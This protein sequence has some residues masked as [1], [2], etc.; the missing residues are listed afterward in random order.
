MGN[1]LLIGCSGN[2]GTLVFKELL[3]VGHN[4]RCVKRISA[5]NSDSLIIP[6]KGIINVKDFEPKII[7]NLANYYSQDQEADFSRM[8]DSTLGVATAI[9][10]QNVKWKAKI[11]HTSTYFQ[12][13][14]SE[15]KPWSNYAELKT[16]S[17]V[18]LEESCRINKVDLIN[19]ILYDNYGGKNKSKF[20]DLLIKSTA[21]GQSLHA[22]LGEQVLNLVNIENI[23]SAIIYECNFEYQKN[24]GTTFNYDLRSDFTCSLLNL[25]KIVCSTLR[26]ESRVIWGSKS[27]RPKEVFNLWDAEFASPNYWNPKNEIHNYITA[28]ANQYQSIFNN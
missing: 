22:T 15:M 24:K 16:K 3:K 13:C 6:Y 21:L 28:Q 27:Y 19:F 2:I 18:I 8:K 9:A 20:F 4:V 23:V 26:A 11:I 17:L 10:N 25:S 12:Y 1:I 7:I 5:K 14:P